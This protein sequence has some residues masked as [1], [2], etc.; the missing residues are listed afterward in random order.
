MVQHVYER[1]KRAVCLDEVVVATDDDRIRTAVK[2]FGGMVAMT[3]A[4][5]RSGTDRVAEA[6]QNMDADVIV[7]IQG[8]EPMLDPAMLTELVNPFLSGTEANFGHAEK[9][10]YP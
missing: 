1:A 7:N 8:D 10:G 6:I 9:A 3:G 2:N 4:D 5:H